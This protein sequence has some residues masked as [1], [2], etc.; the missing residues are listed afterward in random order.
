VNRAVSGTPFSP[1]DEFRHARRARKIGSDVWRFTRCNQE[2]EMATLH[3]LDQAGRRRRAMMGVAAALFVI[4]LAS[5]V[6]LHEGASTTTAATRV[7]LVATDAVATIP[8]PSLPASIGVPSAEGV[9]GHAR[10][11]LPEEPIAQF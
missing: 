3:Q 5:L 4:G 8:T 10:Y 6:V 7:S 9:F 1:N 11:A 2:I